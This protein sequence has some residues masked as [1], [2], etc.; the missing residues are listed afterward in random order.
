MS[1]KTIILSYNEKRRKIKIP[2]NFEE[3]KD[4]F[5]NQFHEGK[6]KKF[7]FSYLSFI[8][9]DI[10]FT[11]LISQTN[12]N[13]PPIINVFKEKE[14][15]KEQKKEDVKE[16]VIVG[17]SPEYFLK[18]KKKQRKKQKHL[19]EKQKEEIKLQKA[20]T[21]QETNNANN[22]NYKE[23]ASNEGNNSI[24]EIKEKK[25]LYGMIKKSGSENLN[26]INLKI[27]DLQPSKEIVNDAYNFDGVI[28]AFCVFQSIDNLLYIVYTTRFNSIIS[29]N[30]SEE[31]KIKEIKE[32]HNDKITN[33]RYCLDNK[34]KLD[35]IIS[36]SSHNNNI[37]LWKSIDL[38]LLY[39][40][41]NINESGSLKSACF[42]NYK[43]E[44]FII[45]SS[46]N[47]FDKAKPIK[48]YELNGNQ[49]MEINNSKD[50]T[51][52]ID[53][54]YDSKL[55]KN[56]IFTGNYYDVKSYDF[57]ENKLYYKYFDKFSKDHYCAIINDDDGGIT[58]LIESSKDGNVRIWDFHSGKLMNKIQVSNN[59][60]FDLC[61][62]D[63]NY[64]FV[65]CGE[66]IIKLIDL[67][68]G[69]KINTLHDFN[70]VISLKKINHPKY[71]KCLISQGNEIEQIMLWIKKISL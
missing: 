38:I 43:E 58:K 34:N 65:G 32:A 66:E 36:I 29:F 70:S 64:L 3:L 50:D 59:R 49:K 47:N 61:L 14:K 25:G 21:H 1:Q 22:I 45:V 6:N 30:I 12:E 54:Y 33:F 5:F 27:I 15:E 24:K 31:K 17:M 10:D 68:L 7:Y 39:N 28:N 53:V 23:K 46:S 60:L 13:N 62:W 67:E 2:N 52:F 57:N 20:K 55:S 26:N 42:L 11:K 48:V 16:E 4:I 69:K 56:Y 71:G 41:E 19:E 18:I 35:L 44:I 63:N 51:Y 8:D 37:K 9:K 40:F